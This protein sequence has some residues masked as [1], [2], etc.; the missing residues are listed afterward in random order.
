MKSQILHFAKFSKPASVLCLAALAGLF[1]L[2]TGAAR[3]FAADPPAQAAPTDAAAPLQRE[4][5][6]SADRQLEGAW[7][8]VITTT[9]NPPFAVPFRILRTV[10]P[11]GVVDA[12]AFPSITPTKPT[13]V[14]L[15]NTSGHGNW[16]VLDHGYYSV[17]VK[18]FQLNPSALN[19]LDSVGTVRENIR[20]APDGNSYDSVF[21]TTID[22]GKG[23][24]FTNQG[25][26]HATRIQVQPLLYLP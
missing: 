11:T 15:V 22:L 20:M 17:T 8:I 13:G 4:A 24:T 14:P 5:R 23:V 12:Y 2:E 3:L 25:R 10:T 16:G 6:A 18:Y 19:V 21:E 7:D 9:P 26:T 1:V